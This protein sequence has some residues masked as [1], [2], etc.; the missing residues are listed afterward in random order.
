M[1]HIILF[2]AILLTGCGKLGGLQV[3][4]NQTTHEV[5]QIV[6]QPKNMT[7]PKNII[8]LVGDGMGL[9][10]VYSGMTANKGK[11]FLESCPY[12]GLSKT[13]ASDDYITDSAAGATAFSIGQKTYNGAIGVD[14]DG[15]PVE[16]ILETAEKQGLA[17]G[18]VASCAITHAT[19]ASFIA[20]QAK[21]SMQEEIA[22][23]FL[24]TDIDVFLGGGRQFFEKRKDGRNLSEELRK[25]GYQIA[26]TLDEVKNA[27]NGKLAGLL[28]D[29]HPKKY[30]DGRG[31]M[32]ADMSLKAIEILKQNPKG[33]FLMIEGSQIDWG[34]H[35]NEADYVVSEMLDFD[36]TIGKVLEFAA[37]DGETLVVITADHETGGLTLNGGKIETGEVKARFTTLHHTA[38]AVPVFS[39]G[40]GAERFAGFYENTSIYDKMMDLLNLKK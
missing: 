10:Q 9:T 40:V 4:R 35:A 33:F 36:R 38:V 21:R 37:K 32:L 18:M 30:L 11:L 17:T 12:I 28:A 8:F 20:H 16:T 25:S 34:G 3:V 5:R 31:N 14:K 13:Y 7:K 22:A 23:D 27:K 24:K 39:F 15:K 6:F 19:P 1:K 2:S 26:Y 29:N